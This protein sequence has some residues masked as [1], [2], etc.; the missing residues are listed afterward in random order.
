MLRFALA[1]CCLV[2]AACGA[3]DAAAEPT[4]PAGTTVAGVDISGLSLPQ[5]AGRLEAAFGPTLRS[6]VDVRV[7]AHRLHLTERGG[8]IAFDAACSAR[9]ASLCVT[10]D[11]GRLED[12]LDRVERSGEREPRDARLRYTVTKLKV[13]RERDGLRVDRDACARRSRRRCATRTRRA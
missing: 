11:K 5:A 2:L 3:T 6:T 13:A 4:V 10:W 7:G 12:F 1:L 9:S 8:R